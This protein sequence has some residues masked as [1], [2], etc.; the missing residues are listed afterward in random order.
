MNPMALSCPACQGEQFVCAVVVDSA[1][2][3]RCAACSLGM[4]L[5]PP[6]QAD[7]REQFADDPAYFARAY[8]QPKD[9]WW[10]RFAAAPLDALDACG[11]GHGQ[12]FLDVGCNLGY[13][14]EAA[15][16]RGYH[17][18]GLD[19]SAAAVAFGRERLGLDLT[20]AR[21]E[22]AQVDPASQDVIV[23]NHVLEHLPDPGAALRLVRGWLRPG[24]LLLIGLP[25]F[26][27]PI[28]RFAGARWAGLVPAQHVWHFTPAALRH[29]VT[30]TGFAEV[31][32]QT[33]MLTYVPKGAKGWTLYA[34][35]RILEVVGQADN[36][37]LVARKL[38]DECSA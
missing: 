26:A 22:S 38:T 13:L 30:T 10:H 28:A 5:P 29:L 27:S 35:R 37:I 21:I 33:R 4:T 23:L 16:R 15:K 2:V 25:N 36:L 6:A 7:G 31:R 8:A 20:H 11:A 12:R 14:V 9:R 18:R 32:W 34:I 24:G 1:A 17:A 19:G 3:W